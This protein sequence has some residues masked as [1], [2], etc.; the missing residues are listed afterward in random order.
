MNLLFFLLGMVFAKF[1]PLLDDVVELITH[2]IGIHTQKAGVTLTKLAKE[3]QK[4]AEEDE[5]LTPQIGFVVEPDEPEEDD[6]FE[7]E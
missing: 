1:F 3:A 7:D 2:S 4:I 5:K 6:E